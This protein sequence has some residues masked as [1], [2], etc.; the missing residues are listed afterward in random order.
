MNQ[1]VRLISTDFDGTI[2]AESES[3][4]IAAVLQQTLRAAQLGGARWVINTGRDLASLLDAAQ[5][6]THALTADYLVLVEREIYVRNGKD[7][8]PLPHWNRRCHEDH[9]ALF[10][11]VRRDV[12]RLRRWITERFEAAVFD[13]EW[14][15]L[16]IVARDNPAADQILAY[17]EA[18][19]REVPHLAVMRNDVYARMCHDHYDKGTALSEIARQHGLGPEVVFA[20]GDHFNDLPMLSTRHAARLA[21]PSNAID[22]VKQAVRAQGGWVASQPHGFGVAEALAHYGARPGVLG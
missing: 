9:A 19:C 13:D 21:A 22:R 2:F 16:C 11:L 20:A 8:D 10:E 15:P 12:P 1:P 17:L 5:S 3:P 4:S 14:S 7:F 18:Y 6:A